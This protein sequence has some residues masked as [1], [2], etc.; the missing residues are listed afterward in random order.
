MFSNMPETFNFVLASNHTVNKFE[1]EI[2]LKNSFDL[3]HEIEELVDPEA[4][5]FNLTQFTRLQFQS[6]RAHLL[7]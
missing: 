7:T 5:L 6:L 3:L 2:S 1:Q 4:Q